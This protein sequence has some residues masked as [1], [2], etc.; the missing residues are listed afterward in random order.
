M[1]KSFE[2]SA[3]AVAE[4]KRRFAQS[5]H[6]DPIATL[7]QTTGPLHAGP[8][9]QDAI[10]GEVGSEDLIAI[11]RREFENRLPNLEFHLAVFVYDSS[12][13]DP[14]DIVEISGVRFAMRQAMRDALSDLSLDFGPEGFVFRAPD[15]SIRNPF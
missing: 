13:C 15:G 1:A 10:R 2:V 9:L 4:I 8:E 14:T 3:Q 11:G 12:E 5:G 6:Q 7:G